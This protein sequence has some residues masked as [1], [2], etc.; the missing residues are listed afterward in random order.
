MPARPRV[1]N[2]NITHSQDEVTPTYNLIIRSSKDPRNPR[3]ILV[4]EAANSARLP[5]GHMTLW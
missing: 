5:K 3:P 2:S 4:A 1:G